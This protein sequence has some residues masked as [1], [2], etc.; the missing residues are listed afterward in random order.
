MSKIS[1]E[2]IESY[3]K[4]VLPFVSSQL[5]RANFEGQGALDRAE[6]EH[7]CNEILDLAISALNPTGD[8]IP[9]EVLK[10]ITYINRGNFNTVEGIREWI[11]NAPAVEPEITNDDL[12]AAM[13]ESYHLG[14][15]LA[16]TK[17]KRPQGVWEY[18]SDNY[19]VFY[20]C[21]KCNGYGYIRD[22]FCKH[23]GAEMQK[24][25]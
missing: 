17:F 16:E 6:F 2:L 8:C 3:R 19:T 9:R 13:T 22:K 15:G 1:K 18:H 21:S 24:G 5:Y 12:Q 7:D 11:D 25:E 4:I 20:T 10:D 14:Y 23:C